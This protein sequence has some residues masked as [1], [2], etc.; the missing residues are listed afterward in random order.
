MAT[1]NGLMVIG[2]V[3]TVL[4]LAS[5][6]SLE[7]PEQPKGNFTIKLE[8]SGSRPADFYSSLLSPDVGILA[9]P[10]ATT[11]FNCFT[12]NVTGTRI[13][14]NAKVAAGCNSTNNFYGVGAGVFAMPATRN[15]PMEVLVPEGT[16]RVIDVY[17]FYPALPECGGAPPTSPP[18]LYRLGRVIADTMT[19]SSVTV[20]IS[21]TSESLS[22]KFECPGLMGHGT[23]VLLVLWDGNTVHTREYNPAAGSVSAP[24][25]PS[26]SITGITDVRPL[27]GRGTYLYVNN[28]STSVQVLAISNSTGQLQSAGSAGSFGSAFSAM[29]VSPQKNLLF[30]FNGTNGYSQFI[31]TVMP[32]Q[33]SAG[34]TS[35]VPTGVADS[36]V[37]P[38]GN[39][40][41]FSNLTN[42]YSYTIN[43][44]TGAL[45]SA[46]SVSDSN[47]YVRLAAGGSRLYTFAGSTINGYDLNTTSGAFTAVSGSPFASTGASINRAA[48][49]PQNRYLWV[50]STA[51]IEPFGINANGSIASGSDLSVGGV[52]AI[53]TDPAGSKLFA[54]AG[55]N[56]VIYDIINSTGDISTSSIVSLGM[57]PT[58][59]LFHEID[60]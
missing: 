11:D 20:P 12:A 16:Q 54:V 25:G 42:I 27:P 48:I 28:A 34:A 31:S 33:L 36:V 10:S 15:S 59:M 45:T 2:A 46:S 43:N 50:Y 6:C 52:T 38:N 56:L 49:D 58:G 51:G 17:G 19:N 32:N 8:D 18:Y 21:L 40:I 57:S 29:S 1:F 37:H 23:K 44:A 35:T 5:G 30:G 13:L 55:S 4:G 47:T 9:D 53:T 41:F 24:L 60:Y 7:K 39:L 14:S 26:A 3:A 22:N